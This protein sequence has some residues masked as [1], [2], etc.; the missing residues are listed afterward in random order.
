MAQKA[1]ANVFTDGINQDFFHT[2]QKNTVLSD[3]LNATLISRN[4]NELSLQNDMGN[5]KLIYREKVTNAEGVV[6]YK[7]SEVKLPENFVPV[8]MKEYGGIVYILSTSVPEKEGDKKLFQIGSFPGPKFNES[9]EVI[10]P[11]TKLTTIVPDTQIKELEVSQD[12]LD[13][14][15]INS[16][17]QNS[18]NLL[19]HVKEDEATKY[20]FRACDAFKMTLFGLDFDTITESE[21]NRKLYTYKI[22]NTYSGSDITSALRTQGFYLG[23]NQYHSTYLYDDNIKLSIRVWGEDN[24]FV[25][26]LKENEAQDL[27]NNAIADS[28]G[29]YCCVHYGYKEQNNIKDKYLTRYFSLYSSKPL[30]RIKITKD[31]TD[32]IYDDFDNE[33]NIKSF[34]KKI[35]DKDFVYYPNIKKGNLSIQF[36]LEKIDDF[37]LCRI[38]NGYVDYTFDL[39][40]DTKLNVTESVQKQIQKHLELLFLC[41]LDKEC[42]VNFINNEDACETLT[43][44]GATYNTSENSIKIPFYGKDKENKDCKYCDVTVTLQE[45]KTYSYYLIDRSK[46]GLFFE[47]ELEKQKRY[48]LSFPNILI[49]DPSWVKVNALEVNYSL[50]DNDDNKIIKEKSYISEVNKIK[51]DLKSDSS[52]ANDDY[53]YI[54]ESPIEDIHINKD[55]VY[56]YT[57]LENESYPSQPFLLE[58]ITTVPKT[59]GENIEYYIKKDNTNGITVTQPIYHDDKNVTLKINVRPINTDYNID[60][61]DKA[62]TRT[63]DLS[64]SKDQWL[65][66]CDFEETGDK[67]IVE[68]NFD[69]F[70]KDILEYKNEVK[71]YLLKKDPVTDYFIDNSTTEDTKKV[72]YAKS[73]NNSLLNKSKTRSATYI[74]KPN[75]EIGT[76]TFEMQREKHGTSTPES[77]IKPVNTVSYVEAK[78]YLAGK[79]ADLSG[80]RAYNVIFPYFWNCYDA[81]ATVGY[82]LIPIYTYTVPDKNMVQKKLLEHFYKNKPQ[83]INY[84]DSLK[85]NIDFSGCLYFMYGTDGAETAT[86]SKRWIKLFKNKNVIAEKK[87]EDI[88][89]ACYL[90][91]KGSLEYD[92]IISLSWYMVHKRSQLNYWIGL[93]LDYRRTDNLTKTEYEQNKNVSPLII[94]YTIKDVAIK[95]P[96]KP[97]LYDLGKLFVIKNGDVSL[98]CNI[99]YDVL[100]NDLKKIISNDSI[101]NIEKPFMNHYRY[102]IENYAVKDNAGSIKDIYSLIGPSTNIIEMKNSFPATKENILFSRY[103]FKKNNVIAFSSQPTSISPNRYYIV[104]FYTNHHVELQ[105]SFESKNCEV[106]IPNYEEE[107][108]E[109]TYSDKVMEAKE[110]YNNSKHELPQILKDCLYKRYVFLV[111]PLSDK[112]DISFKNLEKDATIYNPIY[113]Q[114]EG[115]NTDDIKEISEDQ[116]CGFYKKGKTIIV[117]DFNVQ[118]LILNKE[119]QDS[120]TYTYFNDQYQNHFVPL[121]FFDIKEAQKI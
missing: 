95:E 32:I 23:I 102:F 1:N 54:Y 100:Y 120:K 28:L 57:K 109:F 96:F 55:V 70:G 58:K 94:K 101:E 29:L 116:R 115:I 67:F 74:Q 69:N 117:S 17:L 30:T 2:N 64:K 72:R 52:L 89:K 113:Y 8:G 93:L 98:P 92:D 75:V 84:I 3:A 106:Y 68:K 63:I 91:L 40:C 71:N 21:E 39:K 18:Y 111:K 19:P 11:D 81:G 112:I 46:H 110:I 56:L 86:E 48:Y 16:S 76:F 43:L 25:D 37:Q 87:H 12:N 85:V 66:A 97:E 114:I 65:G 104:A 36:E 108:N 13:R 20:V 90:N 9:K 44:D 10:L 5:T 119:L 53:N 22:I 78:P 47:L 41:G 83:I 14:E 59:E 34:H 99:N 118:G 49:K 61:K 60:L 27:E 15:K 107:G 7:D 38:N 77:F 35:S 33:Y 121:P 45:P 79:S 31:N 42:K 88:N 73:N 26:V 103:E 105:V 51:T 24:Q 50:I 80:A 62:I 4:G 6:E 82:N